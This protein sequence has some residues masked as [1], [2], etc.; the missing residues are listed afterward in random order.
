MLGASAYTFLVLV[1][2][3]L[4]FNGP[5]ISDL[6]SEG[7]GEKRV[8]YLLLGITLDATFKIWDEFRHSKASAKAKT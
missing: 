6:I 5:H 7:F 1:A 4:A 3:E 8:G 2:S